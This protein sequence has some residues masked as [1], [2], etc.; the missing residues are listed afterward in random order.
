MHAASCAFISFPLSSRPTLPQACYPLHCCPLYGWSVVAWVL[1]ILLFQ[2][3]VH[4]V[5]STRACFSI[6]A[7]MLRWHWP[8]AVSSTGA[9]CT[10]MACLLL[11]SPCACCAVTACILCLCSKHAHCLHV[12]LIHPSTTHVTSPS[13]RVLK[14]CPC[15]WGG[16]EHRAETAPTAG[17]KDQHRLPISCLTPAAGM[18]A[19]PTPQ[20]QVI[21][22][23]PSLCVVSLTLTLVAVV[24]WYVIFHSCRRCYIVCFVCQGGRS[25]WDGAVGH[26]LHMATTHTQPTSIAGSTNGKSICCLAESRRQFIFKM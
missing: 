16:F 9:C 12:V 24:Q 10:V 22:I 20:C 8:N 1:L 25:I 4:A 17:I 11:P 19:P 3:L 13:V 26:N 6:N 23:A 21:I 14:A 18:T 15:D 5:I 2:L 7:C